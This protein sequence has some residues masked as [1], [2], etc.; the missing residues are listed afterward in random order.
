MFKKKNFLKK[1]IF[2]PQIINGRS[3]LNIISFKF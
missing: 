2:S 1:I 3:K